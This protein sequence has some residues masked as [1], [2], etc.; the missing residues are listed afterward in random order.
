VLIDWLLDPADPAVRHLA[1]RVLLDGPLD[2]PPWS[3]HA[4]KQ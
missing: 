1:L 3:R 4:A 2:D